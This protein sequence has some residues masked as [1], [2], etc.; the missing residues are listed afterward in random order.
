VAAAPYGK[1]QP[2]LACEH[3]DNCHV[4][5]IR[6]PDD[7]RWTPVESA[8]KDPARLLVL[9]IVRLDH[10]AAQLGAKTRNRLKRQRLL[11]GSSI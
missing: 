7:E 6:R 4:G 5:R 10:T 1:R 8:E 3:D 11:H 2:R 9:G